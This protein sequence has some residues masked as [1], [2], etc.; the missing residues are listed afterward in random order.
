MNSGI[1]QPGTEVSIN[2]AIQMALKHHQAGK[3]SEAEQIYMQVLAVDPDH[4]DANH[5]LGTIGLQVGKY[6]IAIQF[7]QKAIK[8]A[9]DFAELYNKQGL[10]FKGTGRINDAVT[11]YQKAISLNP[12]FFMA[13]YNMGTAFQESQ[14]LVS[15]IESYNKAL[16][17]KPDYFEAL[18]NLGLA[19]HDSGQFDKAVA[20]YNKA[21][22]INDGVAQVFQNLGN[23]QN[24]TGSIN[25]AIES[26]QRALE[27]D[28]DFVQ[29][30]LNLGITFKVSN[31]LEKAMV[32]LN[33]AIS[34]KPDYGEA[35]YNLGIVLQETGQ[36]E[37]AVESYQKA[38]S[39]IPDNADVHCNLGIALQESGQ[40][41]MAIISYQKAVAIRPDFA[42]AHNNLGNAFQES[43][44][45][46]R[47]IEG[48]RK[49]LAAAPDFA[50]AHKYLSYS[51]KHTEHDNDISAMETL[52]SNQNISNKDKMFLGF[53]LGKAF[54]D[55]KMFEKSIEFFIEA[56][57]L[58]RISYN[59]DI[60][61]DQA[62]FSNIKKTFSSDLFSK[63]SQYGISDKTPLFIVG[64]PRSGT[65][66]VEQ[67]L[68]THPLVF[69]AGELEILE[70]IAKRF[71]QDQFSAI[72]PQSIRT[73][74][75][76]FKK[77]GQDYINSIRKISLDAEHITDKLPHNFM[78]IGLIKLI[79]PGA[80]IIHC[81]R[82]P[83]DTCF[84]IYKHLFEGKNCLKY[85]YD[86]TELGQFYKLY[87]DLMAYWRN[88]LPHYFYDISYE[89]LVSNQE[90]ETRKL[91]EF[92]SL[93]WDDGCLS[94]YKTQ[95]PVATASS[96]QVRQPVYKDSIQL[97]KRYEDNLSPLKKA[98]YA[99]PNISLNIRLK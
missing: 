30:H 32:C 24:E 48:Y 5:Y 90:E 43:G 81:K 78:Q 79:L 67:I 88:T 54:S 75:K 66:L 92:C 35:H 17:I 42:L 27:L 57:R 53:G 56:N 89:N 1:N 20:N 44:L 45:L 47:A 83:M 86:M 19:F 41:D 8:A 2:Q 34:I 96:C 11:S 87:L 97:W 31:L 98:I 46:D 26:Y 10:A 84:S 93:P 50:P 14:N 71:V 74:E 28:P 95:R 38:L 25:E 82:D 13:Y 9:P 69:G 63:H 37:K 51:V 29:A 61:E 16:S 58:K 59:Y 12:D 85:A 52:Y 68:A 3:L 6:D 99:N 77:A 4:V 94:F 80:R 22:A 91:L 70:K 7:F 72:T 62:V 21:V 23:A 15:A 55:L 39:S 73:V 40:L 64:M 36:L 49:S 65:T 33:Q 76:E 60:E 18:V